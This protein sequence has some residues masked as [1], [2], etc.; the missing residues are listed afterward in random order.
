MLGGTAVGWR[1]RGQFL[2]WMQ[3]RG[4][5]EIQ[6][7]KSLTGAGRC[8]LRC[9]GHTAMGRRPW[10]IATQTCPLSTVASSI[11]TWLSSYNEPKSREERE[12]G[13]SYDTYNLASEV[14]YCHLCHVLF[15]GSKSLT[16][17]SAYNLGEENQALPFERR[18]IKKFVDIC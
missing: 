1:C 16:D 10:F 8:C 9:F 2:M 17:S 4:W 11:Y 3:S 14:V 12:Q 15:V 5:L 18:S 6:L 13:R 7:C